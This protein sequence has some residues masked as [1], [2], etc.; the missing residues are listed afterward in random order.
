MPAGRAVAG[1]HRDSS[2]VAGP[3]LRDAMTARC[4]RVETRA[5]HRRVG[6]QAERR[7]DRTASSRYPIYEQKLNK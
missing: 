5:K 2:S 4:A 3:R 6:S 7:A 1:S